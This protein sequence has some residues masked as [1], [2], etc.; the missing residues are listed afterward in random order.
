MDFQNENP[1]IIIDTLFSEQKHIEKEEIKE[2][3]IHSVDPDEY[4]LYK[5]YLG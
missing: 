3:N 1:D 5:K 2:K 4:V